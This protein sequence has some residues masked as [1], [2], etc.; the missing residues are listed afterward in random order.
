MMPIKPEEPKKTEEIK[1]EK[2]V[3]LEKA[4]ADANAKAQEYLDSW[5]RAQ[6]DFI[7]Y[8]RY[9]EQEKLDL[10]QYSCSQLIYSILPVLDDFERAYASL[11]EANPQWVEG[12]R[13][14]ENKLRSILE[15]QGVKEIEAM[16]KPF[17]PVEH[18]GLLHIKGPEGIVVGEVRKGY[19]LHDK[20]L[21]PAQVMVGNGEV[22]EKPVHDKKKTHG[23]KDGE[24]SRD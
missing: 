7:N 8:K 22:E 23:G 20:V 3:D 21:R 2:S 6:A 11:T 12:V 13:L 17:N 14:V 5:K 24:S 4:L 15:S 16:G 10:G 19:R 9:S 18:E 1:E